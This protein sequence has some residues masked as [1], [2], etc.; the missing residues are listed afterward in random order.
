M[1]KAFSMTGDIC[2]G[3]AKDLETMKPKLEKLHS[4]KAISS[5][6]PVLIYEQDEDE[7][8]RPIFQKIHIAHYQESWTIE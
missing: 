7:L 4:E 2:H 1:V 5:T 6:S 8:Q 3:T